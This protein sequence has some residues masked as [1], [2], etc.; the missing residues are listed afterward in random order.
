MAE[1]RWNKVKQRLDSIIATELGISFISSPVH[2]KT[3]YS[4][5]KIVFFHVKL[6][7][8]IIWRFPKD[9][10]QPNYLC[11]LG[12]GDYDDNRKWA[13]PQYPINSIINYL[14]LPK[15]QLLHFED[16]AGIADILKVCDKRIGYDLLSSLEL[17][18]AAKKIYDERF[19]NK[20]KESNIVDTNDN[21]K[22]VK[23]A[24]VKQR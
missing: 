24:D 1:Q 6:D 21:N 18:P 12:Y 22:S 7:G 20:K 15:E 9:S 2:K 4:E 3:A 16:K 10:E 13:L 17:P 23:G 8:E 5:M 19:K 11:V 14:D